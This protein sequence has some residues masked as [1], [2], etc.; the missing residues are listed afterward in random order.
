MSIFDLPSPV[1]IDA[2]M[3]V[4]ES[5][6]WANLRAS[7]PRFVVFIGIMTFV[8]FVPHGRIEE[9]QWTSRPRNSYGR[10]EW[11]DLVRGVTVTVSMFD[12][13]E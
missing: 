10:D 4:P 5:S 9:Y 7:S 11:N 2:F 8:E 6:D 13:L 3:F 12:I 1:L